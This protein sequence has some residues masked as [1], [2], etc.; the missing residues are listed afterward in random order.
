MNINKLLDRLQKVKQTGIDK[1]IA[2]CPAHDDKSPSLGIA[3]KDDK[4][5]IKCFSGCGATQILDA[6]GLDYSALFP[7]TEGPLKYKP[8]FSKSDLFDKLLEQT[9][10]LREAVQIFMHRNLD[11]EEWKQALKAMETVDNIRAEVRTSKLYV[12]KSLHDG[13]I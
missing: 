6:V 2:C 10:L 9:C 12:P 3:I 8:K 13:A 4:V 5:L 11:E 7:E 1:W